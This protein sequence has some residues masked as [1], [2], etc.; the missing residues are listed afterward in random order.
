MREEEVLSEKTTHSY[1]GFED[2]A[3]DHLGMNDGGVT[4][5]VQEFNS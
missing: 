5:K 2:F 1:E 3:F 4:D